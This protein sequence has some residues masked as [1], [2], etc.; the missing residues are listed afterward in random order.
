[1]LAQA[2][3]YPQSPSWPPKAAI[4]VLGIILAAG[5]GVGI[6]TLRETSSGTVRNSR[7]VFELCGTPPIALI[8]TIYNR[9]DRIKQKFYTASG[10]IVVVVVGSIAYLA[11][12]GF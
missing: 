7:E 12:A 3:D 11:A 2:P 6:A 1:V 5:A 10:L 8:P 4:I 9:E